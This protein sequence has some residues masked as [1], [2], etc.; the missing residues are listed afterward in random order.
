MKRFLAVVVVLVLLLAGVVVG[1]AYVLDDR[2][3]S[4]ASD[5][6][7]TE[8]QHSVPFTTRP[9]VTLEGDP[10]ALHL[11][12]REFPSVRVEAREMP[13][14][15]DE[16]TWIPL[17]D[18]DFTLT[19]VRYEQDAVSAAT[20]TGGGWLDYADLSRVAG[21]SIAPT[22]DGRLAFQR[23]VEILGTTLTGRL[24]GRASL[25]KDAQ[26]ITLADTELDLAG[27]PIP[28]EATQPLVDMLL[29]PVPV[30]LPYGIKLDALAPGEQGLDV[31]VDATD[32]TFPIS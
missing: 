2:I 1:G 17:Y 26:T 18:V 15:T 8:L 6:V 3:R 21:T 25:D 7:A 23:E 12:T 27:V 10:I 5:R 11:V 9:R 22:E 30:Q 14:Q 20:L 28:T 29:S 19:D 32:V 16:A 31:T 4:I 24:L 13:V